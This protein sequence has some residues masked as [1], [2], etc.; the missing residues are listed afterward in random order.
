VLGS[1]ERKGKKNCDKRART[2]RNKKKSK[3]KTHKKKNQTQQKGQNW[4]NYKNRKRKLGWRFK[5]EPGEP[6]GFKQRKDVR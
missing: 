4:I 1:G 5:E 2:I 3:N 6:E